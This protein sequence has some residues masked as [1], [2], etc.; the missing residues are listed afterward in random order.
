MKPIELGKYGLKVTPQRVAVLDAMKEI[1]GHPTAETVYE[2][3][4]NSHPN[5][6]MG[7]VYNILETFTQKGL[8][9]RIKTEKDVMRYELFSPDHHHLY[10]IDSERI[11][12]YHDAKINELLRNYFAENKIP[13]F[14]ITE[15]KLQI[16]GRFTDDV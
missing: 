7:T 11:E 16:T 3:V 9:S 1:N 4:R 14:S 8:V 15:V 10:S 6:S 13:N 12:D 5:I 2:H